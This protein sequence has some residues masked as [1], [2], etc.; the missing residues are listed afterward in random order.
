MVD[1]ELIYVPEGQ[2]AIHLYLRLKIGATVDDVLY[3]S[4]LLQRYP[5]IRNFPVGVFGHLVMLSNVVRSGDRVEI[6]R[7]L[8]ADPKEKRRQ[9]ARQ[10]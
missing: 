2:S 10:M 3:E 1:V 6:Y 9:R 8:K 4:G 5:E 7:P